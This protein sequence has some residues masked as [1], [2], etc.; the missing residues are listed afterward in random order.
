[1]LR[2]H[3]GAFTL[4]GFLLTLAG[5]AFAQN[6]GTAAPAHADG[7]LNVG[8]VRYIRP[9]PHE[10]VIEPT[11]AALKARF[12]AA[13]V[14]TVTLTMD[15]LTR[16]IRDKKVDV[17]IASAGFY[18]FNVI[19]GAR[20]LVTLAS[21]AYPDPNHGDGSVFVT[22]ASTPF[23]TIESL[24]GSRLV[25]ATPTGFTSLRI[26]Q[27]ELAAR[28]YNPE[29]FFR[30][31]FF[32]GPG[33][34]EAAVEM[35]KSYKA[36]T[37]VFR[38]CWLEDYLKAHPEEKNLWRVVEPKPDSG[39]CLAST[40]LY[41]SW[42]VATTPATPPAVSRIVTETLLAMPE[43]REGQYWSVATDFSTIDNLYKTLKIG[44]YQF[45]REWSVTR[46]W[47]T[48]RLPIFLVIGL[49]VGLIFHSVRVTQLV[50]RKT[51]ELTEALARETELKQEAQQA[52][53]RISLLQRSGII[54]QMSS[55]IAHELRQPLAAQDLFGKSLEKILTRAGAGEQTLSVLA[56]MMK[57]TER[58]AAIVENVRNYAKVKTVKRT[59]ID[60]RS[61]VERGIA[62]W[63]A[64]GRSD[65]VTV[66][67]TAL[68]PVMIDANALEWE[69]VVLNLIKNA[70]E[71]L[72]TTKDPTVSVSLLR[73]DAGNFVL[74]V[75]DN[76]PGVPEEK[77]K[78][79][80]SPVTSGKTNGLG[81]GLSI[82]KSIV[83]NHGAAIRFR[84]HPLGGLEV[85]VIIPATE[86]E[87][88][89]KD[90]V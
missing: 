64:S 38:L 31:S 30:Q 27:G 39:R 59:R 82:V 1:M 19:H 71:A 45:L 34:T 89:A 26:A 62:S 23:D 50:H 21:R 7:I 60:L 80:G 3:S 47:E 70:A 24:K 69:L 18:R 53:E 5:T 86:S 14:A 67:L 16:S 36:D 2:G 90:N 63:R 81:L 57:Q 77:L 85:T 61:V 84:N 40:D 8:I 79:F 42:I 54:G 25:A 29:K 75:A 46:F 44:P 13:N 35:L 20:D 6:A 43:T 15:E 52:G 76:G 11:I 83:E 66:K 51:R 73:N 9:S 10:P 4:A 88:T 65:K 37:A 78:A 48:F 32:T 74:T 55:M 87:A 17:F 56:R 33:N 58:I 12:G 22:L 72:A 28:G 68:E 49:I 41:P